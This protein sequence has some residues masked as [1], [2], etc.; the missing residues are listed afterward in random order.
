MVNRKGNLERQQL[1]D[2]LRV[3]ST[4]KSVTPPGSGWIRSIRE[5]LGMTQS[6]LGA[7]LGISR[8]SVQDFEK[9]EVERR[10]TLDSLDRLARA[11]GC[12]LVYALAPETGSLEDLRTRRAEALA[13]AML[14]PTTHSMELED[15]G[16]SK[17]TRQRQRKELIDTLLTGSARNLWR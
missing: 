14:E 6:Q 3:Y 8:Q 2:A 5:A 11:M 12:R 13:D 10:I 1:D 7:K 16:V 4:A 15:Q 17:R 9:A